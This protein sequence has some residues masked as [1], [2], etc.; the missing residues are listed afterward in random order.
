[1]F[2]ISK[3]NC[4]FVN[5]RTETSC[6]AAMSRFHDS[7]FQGVRL[8]CRLR[9]GSTPSSANPPAGPI[10]PQGQ[11]SQRSFGG[12]S[13]AEGTF[14]G[15]ETRD[16]KMGG[17]KVPEKY[18]IVKSLTVDDLELSARNGTWATQA[19]NEV[20]LNKAY[21][22]CQ[23]VHH[24]HS[25]ANRFQ[26]AENVYLIFSANKSGTYFGYARMSSNI[27]DEP[28]PTSQQ[29]L[30]NEVQ[31]PPTSD[32]LMAIPTPATTTA[33]KGHIIDDSARGTI[34]WEAD[35]EEEEGQKAEEPGNI[36]GEGEGGETSPCN[37][38]AFGKPFRIEWLS[39]E[40]LPFYR[41]RGLRNPW[42][43]NREVKIA[44]DGTELE[45]SVGKRLVSM[46]HRPQMPSL[47]PNSARTPQYLQ[48]GY[49][50][51]Y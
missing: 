1:M 4:A 11:E 22:V 47:S 2:L 36:S 21:Q 43:S 7:R 34:F 19:H 27:D 51:P 18:F 39:T 12:Q 16:P 14:T 37:P 24:W 35:T 32:L 15:E 3:S 40:A 13:E 23:E 29:P 41:T 31:Q 42:N 45:P 5:Y 38:Q 26:S 33:P 9:R 6:G 17:E 10:D 25:T 50:R 20:A 46:F 8:V 49:T 28:I 48:Q 44:R 30:R